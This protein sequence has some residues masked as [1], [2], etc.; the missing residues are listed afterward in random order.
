MMGWILA[1]LSTLADL[2]AVAYCMAHARRVRRVKQVVEVESLIEA[3]RGSGRD[4]QA[5]Q[6]GRAVAW[7][8]P[9]QAASHPEQVELLAEWM[10]EVDA[11]TAD[12]GTLPTAVV[13]AVL[14]LSGAVSLVIVAG[15]IGASSAS[16]GLQGFLVLGVGIAAAGACFTVGQSA[17]RGAQR[18]RERWDALSAR[19]MGSNIGAIS[20]RRRG[21][22]G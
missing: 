19:L 6:M 10:A 21:T 5:C 2:L 16:L 9:F 7:F 4:E 14:A 13:R 15:Q 1:G 17:R 12:A 11:E 8:A 20:A 18:R 22:Q 3:L